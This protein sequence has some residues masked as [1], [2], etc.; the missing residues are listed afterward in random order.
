MDEDEPELD[1]PGEPDSQTNGDFDPDETGY[2]AADDQASFSQ[3]HS[4]SSVKIPS[5]P[6]RAAMSR[7]PGD[8]DRITTSDITRATSDDDDDD[9]DNSSVLITEL[10]DDNL[11][12]DGPTGEW[13]G[14]QLPK[15]KKMAMSLGD[16]EEERDEDYDTDLE[17]DL[18]RHFLYLTYV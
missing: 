5:L 11:P 17:C 12:D 9:D 7:T 4:P 3:L 14:I 13:E 18:G 8:M 1:L 15:A 6:G 2:L 16:E 10:K